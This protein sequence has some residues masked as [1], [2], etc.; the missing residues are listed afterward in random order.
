MVHQ[1]SPLAVVD[2][3]AYLKSRQ[4]KE[5]CHRQ[6]KTVPTSDKTSLVGSWDGRHLDSRPAGPTEID[7]HRREVSLDSHLVGGTSIGQ[8]F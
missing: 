4:G 3:A 7:R 2:D 5:V 6:Y 1:N 8:D